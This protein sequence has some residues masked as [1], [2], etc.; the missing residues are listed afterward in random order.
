MQLG[1]MAGWGETEGL[2]PWWKVDGSI[3]PEG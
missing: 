3:L 1:E 2:K